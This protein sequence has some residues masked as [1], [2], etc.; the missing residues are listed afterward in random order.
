LGGK[1]DASGLEDAADLAGDG[2][3]GGDALAVFLDRGFLE[4]VEIAQ[5]VSPFDNRSRGRGTDRPALSAAIA[6][7]AKQLAPG[8]KA[9]IGNSAYRRYLRRTPSASSKPSAAFEIDPG[10]LAEEA[11]YVT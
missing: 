3:A 7:L 5:Q 4:A 2:G 11:R 10:K 9:L 8:D 6:G 1:G